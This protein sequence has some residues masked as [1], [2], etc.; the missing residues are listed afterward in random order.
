MFLEAVIYVGN[1]FMH[2]TCLFT[3]VPFFDVCHNLENNRLLVPQY[4]V[5]T[6]IFVLHELH[7]TYWT[8]C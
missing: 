8:I 3:C 4:I 2:L 5:D 7:C 1:L 6:V